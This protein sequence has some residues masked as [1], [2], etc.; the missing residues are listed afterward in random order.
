M[1]EINQNNGS[2]EIIGLLTNIVGLIFQTDNP[3]SHAYEIVKQTA[4]SQKADISTLFVV[5]GSQLKL[6]GG[7]AYRKEEVIELPTTTHLYEL[8]WE[9]T[10]ERDMAKQGLTAYVATSGEAMFVESYEELRTAHLAHA[11][12]WDPLIYPDGL[13]H[14]NTG[15]RC[16]YAVPLRRSLKGSPKETVMGV[17]KI[18]RRRHRL[19]F[20]EDDRKIF[21]LVAA[22]LSLILQTFYRVQNRVFS[23][24]A[25]AIGG[26][27][28]RSYMTLTLCQELLKNKINR[29]KEVFDLLEK[30]LPGAIEMLKKAVTRLTTV[31]EA[32]R[33]PD[34]ITEVT[35]GKLFNSVKVE[36]ELKADIKLDESKMILNLQSP[37]TENTKLRMRSIE[38]HD[39]SSILGNILDNA[40]RYAVTKTPVKVSIKLNEETPTNSL[41]FRIADNGSGIPIEVLREV[42]YTDY[43]DIYRLPGTGVKGTGLRRV[44][45]LANYNNW[46]VS[47]DITK[48]TILDVKTP[49]FGVIPKTSG[50]KNV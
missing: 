25:H 2:H 47:Y 41:I 18:E 40:I 31:L 43:S 28:G 7:V 8:N 36:V 13:N 11:G 45:G 46:T 37:I 21:D 38:Y 26:G 35:I 3:L 48:G 15:F 1:K 49:N 50:V 34:H 12:K 29:P 42:E 20:S 16:L 24:V 9:A 33:D 14:K 44:F 23:D 10:K 17:F 5:E 6:K 19:A 30:H 39:L 22:H 32:S 27:L 4:L